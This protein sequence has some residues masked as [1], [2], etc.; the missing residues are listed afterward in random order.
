VNAGS[1]DS[2]LVR[3]HRT[4][5]FENFNGILRCYLALILKL[6]EW[7]VGCAIKNE[8]A[9]VKRIENGYL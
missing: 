8:F 9:L 3:P 1:K 4:A 5:L 2:R 6:S 7:H